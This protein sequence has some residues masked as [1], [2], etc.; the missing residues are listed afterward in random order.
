MLDADDVPHV[1]DLRSRVLLSGSS[2][3]GSTGQEYDASF[4]VRL[5]AREP[6][7]LRG[8]QAVNDPPVRGRDAQ[9]AVTL[10]D[11][12]VAVDAVG[13]LAVPRRLP[14]GADVQLAYMLQV[15]APRCGASGIRTCGSR[16]GARSG[17][18]DLSWS[19][20]TEDALREE[21]PA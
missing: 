10:D 19:S 4:T 7:E 11:V 9:V 1:T 17:E 3:N 14:E 16:C 21:A 12:P 2:R 5:R 8:V 6:V 13:R 18:G 15:T 20:S